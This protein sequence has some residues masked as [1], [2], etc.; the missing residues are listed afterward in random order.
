M[1]LGNVALVVGTTWAVFLFKQGMSWRLG[2]AVLLALAGMATSGRL[3]QSSAE[4][5][6]DSAD[7]QFRIQSVFTGSLLGMSLAVWAIRLFLRGSVG[8]PIVIGVVAAL[9]W[10]LCFLPPP[11]EEERRKLDERQ[12][13]KERLRPDPITATEAPSRSS[14]PKAAGLGQTAKQYLR[15][16]EGSLYLVCGYCSRELPEQG[17][18]SQCPYCGVR[19]TGTISQQSGDFY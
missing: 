11:S 5:N 18:S 3:I 12:R 7:D 8:W 19:W 13:A 1:L 4:S 10:G 6:A 9:G 17:L 14:P 2:A 16:S 15:G